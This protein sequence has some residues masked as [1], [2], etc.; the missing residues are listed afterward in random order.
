M[1]PGLV[2]RKL[3]RPAFFESALLTCPEFSSGELDSQDA[4]RLLSAFFQA[5]SRATRLFKPYKRSRCKIV[6][7]GSGS[8]SNAT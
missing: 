3:P 5:V 2:R 8:R 7:N 6:D 4:V 1:A